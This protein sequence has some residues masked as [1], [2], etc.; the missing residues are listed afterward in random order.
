MSYSPA[1]PATIVS[2]FHADN[3]TWSTLLTNHDQLYQYFRPPVVD[4]RTA[5]ASVTSGSA[6]D[7][8]EFECLGNADL[9][10]ITFRVRC[11]TAGGNGTLTCASDASTNTATINGAEAWYTVSVT[12]TAKDSICKVKLHKGTGTTMYAHAVEAYLAPSAP[13]K[14][15]LASLFVRGHTRWDDADSQINT[16]IATRL[17]NGPPALAVERPVCVMSA[18]APINAS[19]GGKD[20]S[21]LTVTNTT[22]QECVL[23]ALFPAYDVVA[24]RYKIRM[25]LRNSASAGPVML[26]VGAF[27]ESHTPSSTD[28]WWTTSATFAPGVYW[29]EI[30]ANPGGLKYQQ[31][32]TVQVWRA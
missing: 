32:P 28:E 30:Y 20:A 4:N 15:P 10:P 23:R 3:A 5:T 1:D 29:L 11:S 19:T 18:L 8:Y 21:I 22:S 13:A 25:R 17:L 27:Q 6:T 2:P 31:V 7:V 24:R 16:E 26:R 9:A 12:P 14:A